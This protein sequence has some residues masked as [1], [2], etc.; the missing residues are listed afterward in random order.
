MNITKINSRKRHTAE[1]LS[2]LPRVEE[3]ERQFKMLRDEV[4]REGLDIV[5]T[6]KASKIRAVTDEDWDKCVTW[7]NDL[8]EKDWTAFER[9]PAV[10]Y[11][12]LPDQLKKR[13]KAE[14]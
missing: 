9:V 13:V 6:H 14:E 7:Y 4:F 10:V 3:V 8:C 5:Q 1:K 2:T 11:K 12:H